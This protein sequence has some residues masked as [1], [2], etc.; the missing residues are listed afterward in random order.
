VT[1]PEDFMHEA[2]N[3]ARKALALKEVPVG[4]VIVK[5]GVIVGRGHNTRNTDSKITSHAEINAITMASE[6]LKDWRLEDCS[7]Y[8]T[9][10][11]CAMCAGAIMQSQIKKVYY[12]ALEP[13]FGAH[14]STIH[15]FDSVNQ[16]TDVFSGILAQESAQL[17]T[18]FFQNIR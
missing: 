6:W 9:L 13:K 5:D 3:E 11:P 10:E 15:V 18:E 4:A 12:G 14:V 2:L 7:I 1:R 16:K 17:L 8:V